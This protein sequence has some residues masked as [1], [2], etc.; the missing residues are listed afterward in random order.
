MIS[1]GVELPT[2]GKSTSGVGVVALAN[3]VPVGGGVFLTVGV[4]VRDGF[5]VTDRYV[6]GVGVLFG[7][8]QVSLDGY[9]VCRQVFVAE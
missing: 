6:V 2:T 5:G 3:S 4:G 1:V 9:E 8:V 7:G